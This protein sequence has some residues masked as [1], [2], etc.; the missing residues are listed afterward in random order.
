MEFEIVIQETWT[1]KLS[2][3]TTDEFK[4]L[5]DLYI[6]AFKGS[7]SQDNASQVGSS[8]ISFA[9]VRVV[10]FVLDDSTR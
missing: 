4:D 1:P 7:F 9:E 3:P 8:T 2:D 6:A 10:N 5:A